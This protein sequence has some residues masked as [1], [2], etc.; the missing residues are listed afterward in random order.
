MQ[1]IPVNM[2]PQLSYDDFLPMPP[3]Q[4]TVAPPAASATPEAADQSTTTADS[5]SPAEDSP[6]LAVE[7]RRSTRAVQKPR[8]MTDFVTAAVQFSHAQKLHYPTAHQVTYAHLDPKF[9][10]FI[11]SLDAQQD[12]ITFQEA[13][14][15][16]HWCDAMNAELQALERN[17]TWSLAKIPKGKKA[18][19]CK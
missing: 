7:V 1:P 9:Q 5:T 2:V 12:P 4:T 19:G 8:W 6:S 3:P 14:T 13:V 10:A 11:S 15:H 18:I 16:Q 17:G